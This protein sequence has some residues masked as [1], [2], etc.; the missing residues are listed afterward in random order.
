VDPNGQTVDVEWQGFNT[1]T[2]NA[3][4]VPYEEIR[5]SS[6][7]ES[8]LIS[9]QSAGNNQL[10]V[11]G[12]THQFDGRSQQLLIRFGS[13]VSI[14]GGGNYTRAEKLNDAHQ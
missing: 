14:E 4:N 1:R 8:Y 7:A 11:N 2:G 3:F 13:G 6:G 10:Q 9:S 12:E 5:L